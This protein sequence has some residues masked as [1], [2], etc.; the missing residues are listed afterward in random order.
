MS[1]TKKKQ[2]SPQGRMVEIDG[3]HYM[4]IDGK[5]YRYA[6][7]TLDKGFKITLGRPGSLEQRS[8]KL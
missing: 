1:K 8:L 3:V 5:L 4:L 6:N 2:K 7:L